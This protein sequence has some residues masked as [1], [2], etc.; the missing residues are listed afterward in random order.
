[1]ATGPLIL[2]GPAGGS[3]QRRARL[4]VPDPAR[5]LGVDLVAAGDARNLL[6]REEHEV[7]RRGGEADQRLDPPLE[8]ELAGGAV[9]HGARL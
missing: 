4:G 3:G 6:A 1:M 2:D 8:G 7:E 5:R 9:G